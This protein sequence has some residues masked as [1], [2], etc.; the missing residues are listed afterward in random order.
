[1]RTLAFLLLT[2]PGIS[3]VRILATPE[4]MAVVRSV[5]L[6]DMGLWSA[7]V[8]NDSAVPVSLQRERLVQALPTVRIISSERA[9]AVLAY[10]RGRTKKAVAARVIRYVLIGATAGAGLAQ[11]PARAVGYLAVGLG[12]AD[13]VAARL[14]NDVPSLAPLLSG[15]SDEPLALG[16]G[17]CGSRTV[18]A[19]LQIGA[20]PIE[21]IIPSS[22]Q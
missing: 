22:K 2:I 9:R 16:P 7:A 14:D 5:G 13:Q 6:R 10:S 11:V 18:F 21:A 19:A 4:P 8:C 17:Q 20:K 1:M 3:Q 12:V 15:M